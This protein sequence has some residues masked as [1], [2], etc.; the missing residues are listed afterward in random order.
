MNRLT[1]RAVLSH[2]VVAALSLLAFYLVIRLLVPA[3]FDQ[4]IARGPSQMR[5]AGLRATVTSAITTGALIGGVIG[6]GTAVAIGWLS[7]RRLLRPI[8]Q[9]RAAT[10]HIAAGNYGATVEPPAETELAELA[11]DVNTMAEKLAQIERTRVQLI[12]DV[13]HE[14]R[15]PLTVIDGTLEGMIDGV[16]DATSENLGELG[17]ETRRL[18]RLAEDFSSLAKAQERRFD[19]ALEPADLSALVAMT[20]ARLQPQFEDEGISLMVDVPSMDAVVDPDR[21]TQVITNLLGNALAATPRGGWV[22]VTGGPEGRSARVDIADSG[23]GLTA[24]ESERVFERFYRARKGR[25]S[26]SGIGLTIS[27]EL[28]R[29]HGGDLMARSD[30]PG[31]GATF[32]LWVPLRGT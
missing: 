20:A 11:N 1:T 19:L 29:A 28:M 5:G 17:G 10:R 18:R 21:I 24:E 15:T 2:V 27:R 13:A 8:T 3:L 9:I 12:A 25:A 14:M 31:S 32:S 30:G 6:V 22:H 23:I 26:G 7:S 16:I 4:Q